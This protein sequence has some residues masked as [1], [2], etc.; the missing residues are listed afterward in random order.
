[1]ALI[2]NEDMLGQGRRHQAA[3]RHR[4]L[5]PDRRRHVR[6]DR[7]Q[8]HGRQQRQARRRARL[9]PEPTSRPTGSAFDP[10]G[11]TYGQTTWAG[12]AASLGFKLLDKNPWGTKYN[13]DD[14]RVRADLH[15]VAQHDPQG[16]HAVA[17]AGAHARP[18][19]GVPERQGRAGDRRRLDD[20]HLLGDQ[21]HQGRL[22]AAAR[23]PE[24]QLEHVQRARRRDLGRHQAQARGAQVG[25]LPGL[26]GRARASSAPRP[27][28]SRRS[29]PR[30][31]RRS[32]STRQGRHRRQRLHVL[33]RVRQHGALPD[34]RQGAADQPDRAADARGVPQR[35][36]GRREGVQGHERAGQ[37]PAA[38]SRGPSDARASCAHLTPRHRRRWRRCS[39]RPVRP[40]ATA[41]PRC[42]STLSLAA[43]PRRDRRRHGRCSTARRRGAAR[44]VPAVP[45]PDAGA[46]L[47]AVRGRRA[48]IAPRPGRPSPT[49]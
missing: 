30:S 31:R 47:A 11:L 29:S 20:R 15:L 23:R 32:P 4:D 13:Y 43:L 36:R 26:A 7:R 48:C 22:R 8:A 1:M 16:L 45:E 38:S 24:G 39:R 18:V 6:A 21:G 10:G 42:A 46:Q 2:V 14:P 35:R 27:S 5:E 19:R 41:A 25:Q 9:R 12:F 33:H 40:R 49:P 37:Q 44:A 3:A 34:H 17:G 28:C